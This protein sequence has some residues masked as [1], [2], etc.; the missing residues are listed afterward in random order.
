MADRADKADRTDKAD[1]ADRADMPT[2]ADID[3]K[4]EIM[5]HSLTHSPPPPDS[6]LED[7]IASKN[8]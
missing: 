4:S 7:A 3:D 1:K 5:T 2:I 8:L 6:L